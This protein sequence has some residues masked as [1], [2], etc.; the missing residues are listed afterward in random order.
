[1]RPSDEYVSPSDFRAILDGATGERAVSEFL[2]RK[3]HVLYWS[4]CRIGGHTRFV[5]REFPLGS[6]Y[7][8]DFAVLNSYSGV[9]E[10][11]F[12][13]LE[14][15]DEPPFTKG[16]VV[17]KRL[18]GALKQVGDWADYFEMH[19]EQVRADLVRWAADR[20]LLCYS[21]G[22]RPSNFSGNLLADP[23]TNLHESFHIFIG[24]REKL[25]E[26][27]HKR[28]GQFQRRQHIEVASYDRMLDVVSER[29]KNADYWLRQDESG[30]G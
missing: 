26:D 29:Y 2:G 10:V 22:D 18:N 8:A 17:A 3:P 1:M 6:S 24:R 12:V 4:L 27:E 30:D 9:W 11:K 13:E 25:T 14:P 28:K 16:G 23:R 15:V 5:F 21:E 19:K 20:D 7:V